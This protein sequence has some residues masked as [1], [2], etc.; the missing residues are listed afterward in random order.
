[1]I[2]SKPTGI[3]QRTAATIDSADQ[4]SIV[5]VV[6]E[7]IV[8]NH[9]TR[10]QTFAY[11]VPEGSR[12]TPSATGKLISLIARTGREPRLS[13]DDRDSTVRT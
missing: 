1:M 2:W 13:R 5:G 3:I 4:D 10:N 12:G 9:D 8:L 11:S 6:R 7:D